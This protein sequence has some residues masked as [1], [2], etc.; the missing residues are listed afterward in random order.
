M[1]RKKT[2]EE[3]QPT[4]GQKVN[5]T[6]QRLNEDGIG[7]A[8]LGNKRVIISSVLPGEEALAKIIFVGRHHLQAVPVNITKRS[9]HRV[10]SSACHHK[11][12]DGCPFVMM[13]YNAQRAWK[14]ELVKREITGHPSLRDVAVEEVIPSP[15]P[16]GY[17]NSGKLV[18]A[19]KHANPV[20]GIYR[21]HSHDV[22]DISSCP[23]H[24]PLINKTITVVKEGIRKGKVPIYNGATGNGILR[25]LVVRVSET[26]NQVMV[27][28]VTAIRSY[29]EIHHLAKYIQQNLPEVSVI[30][31][32]V[33]GSAGNVILGPQDSFLTSQRTIEDRIGDTRFSISPRSFF[34]VNGGSAERIYSKVREWANQTSIDQAVDVYCGIG[35]ISLYL[36][37]TA[38]AVTGIEVVEAAVTDAKRNATLNAISNCKFMAG[39]AGELLQE[40]RESGINAQV[41]VLNPPRKG[42]DQLVLQAAAALAPTRLIY[43]SC[44]PAS[45]G[46]DLEILSGYGYQASII[47]P[48]DMF[49]QTPHV[50]CVALLEPRKPKARG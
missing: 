12:C 23:L 14:R 13:D 28:L 31:Q 35:G 7:E 50:E 25:Y 42:C 24:H 1:E 21:R 46:R 33:N 16:L 19:G 48:V 11:A 27:I 6:V 18:V 34:Q 39:D 43:V 41:V 17:R 30:A 2:K 47:Q 5:I 45:L 4:V 20:I 8:I 9:P 3:P 22:I 36:A 26:T 10:K 49:P 44:S 38:R 29:N 32:N 40:I 15:K 37:S